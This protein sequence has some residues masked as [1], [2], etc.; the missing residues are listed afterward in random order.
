VSNEVCNVYTRIDRLPDREK[1][2]LQTASVIGKNFSESILRRV[3]DLGDGD[4]L[5]ALRALTDAEFLY[6]EEFYPEAEYAFKHPLTQEVAYRSQLA[7]RRRCVHGG[8]ARAIEEVGRENLGELTAL[9]AY[10]WEHAGEAREAAKWHRRAAEW[11]GLNNSSETLRHWQ[12]VRHLLDTLPDTQ[13]N[14]GERAAVRGQIMT[15][16]ARLGDSEDQAPL[17]FREGQELATRSGNTHALT[18]VLNG[19]GVLRAQAG[20]TDEA[21]ELLLESVRVADQTGTSEWRFATA[22]ASLIGSPGGYVRAFR[23]RNR[24]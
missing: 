21:L 20:D 7:E 4:L 6:Q 15:H 12:S 18:Q 11:V 16:L 22:L 9:I 14:L 13:E 8:V 24:V 5:P 17:L 23:L 19:F 2:V 3:A 1:Q 10:H